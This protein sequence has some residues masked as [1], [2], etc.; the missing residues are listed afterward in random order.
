[1]FL[2]VISTYSLWRLNMLNQHDQFLSA[3]ETLKTGIIL[4]IW[5]SRDDL[6]ASILPTNVLSLWEQVCH[7]LVLTRKLNINVTLTQATASTASTILFKTVDSGN[8]LIEVGELNIAVESLAGNTF[9]D[10]VNWLVVRFG[11]N[12]GVAT[13][14]CENLRTI[15]RIRNLHTISEFNSDVTQVP[16]IVGFGR[17][18]FLILITP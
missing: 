1:M 14:E 16:P 7:Q 11:D 18:T 9:H 15:D 4:I 10:D 2:Y 12:S 3:D 6:G 17:L 13:K 5:I 8:C